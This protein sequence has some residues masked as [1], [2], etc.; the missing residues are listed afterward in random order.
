MSHR[1][2]MTTT[3]SRVEVVARDDGFYDWPALEYAW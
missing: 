2:A 3:D 1:V